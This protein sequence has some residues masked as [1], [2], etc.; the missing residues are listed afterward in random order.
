MLC[1]LAGSTQAGTQAG[2]K[3]ILI[4]IKQG[5]SLYKL[6]R[7]Y[8]VSESQIAQSNGIK[9]PNDIRFGMHLRI[10]QNGTGSSPQ[11]KNAAN[12]SKARLERVQRYQEFKNSPTR[13]K[14]QKQFQ[15]QAKYQKY[16]ALINKQ[17]RIKAIQYA[18]SAKYQKFLALKAQQKQVLSVRY[19]QQAKY[20]KYL[21]IK[22]QQHRLMQARYAQQAKYEKFVAWQRQQRQIANAS[23]V[24]RVSFG[25]SA[26]M[27]FP[28]RDFRLTDSYGPRDLGINGDHFHTGLDF[29]APPGTPVYAASSGTV[30]S[31]GWG[32]YGKG[33]FVDSGN[34]RVIYGHL[35]RTAVS[36]GE[37]VSRGDVLGYV[38]CTGICTGPH[39]HFEV[40]VDG[41]HVDP[42]PYLP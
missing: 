18:K 21:A 24:Q 15:T 41:Q 3:N 26:R 27:R 8:G 40:Q 37:S 34:T 2:T 20:E 36:E 23:R 5:D 42:R 35:S 6:A 33:V 25:G 28:L 16:L 7:T 11:L 1:F 12:S 17:R 13:A 22:R 32:M 19:A 30:S 29:A 14:L 31:S 9:S 38:G 10:P 4:T 39:L